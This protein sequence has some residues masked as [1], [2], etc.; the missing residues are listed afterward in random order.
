M[1]KIALEPGRG[2][3]ML[4]VAEVRAIVA[5]AHVHQL[6]VT[7][8]AMMTGVAIAL[9]GGVDELAH[10]PCGATADELREIAR[11]RIPVVGTLHLTG[12]TPQA[13]LIVQMGGTLLYGT[14]DGNPGIPDGIDVQELRLMKAAGLTPTQVLAA[15]TSEAADEAGLAPLGT[16]KA[17]AIADV[18]V[19]RGDARRLAQSLAVPRLVV[20]SGVVRSP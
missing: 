16:L 15:A 9:A 18:I 19:V 14:D 11:R 17:G 8:H 7:A 13:A 3:P 4:S 6:I 10:S 2:W 12:C 1:I 20:S 5:E